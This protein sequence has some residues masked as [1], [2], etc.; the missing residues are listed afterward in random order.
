MSVVFIVLP[1]VAAGWPV[2]AAAVGAACGALGYTARRLEAEAKA[3]ASTE[4]SVSRQVELEM[5]GADIIGEALA[6]EQSLEVEKDG[7][8]AT[9]SRDARGKLRLHVDG[10]RS[11]EELTTIGNELLNRVRQQYATEKVKTELA[12]Q[13]FVLVEESVDAEDSIRLSVRRFR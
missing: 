13:G 7:V 11:R 6:R 3:S 5:A 8:I 1:T 10:G 12:Q 2:I 4:T 9:F